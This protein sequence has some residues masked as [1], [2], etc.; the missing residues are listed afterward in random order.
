MAEGPS[1]RTLIHIPTPRQEVVSPRPESPV[2]EEPLKPVGSRGIREE[3]G[4]GLWRV[5][6]KERETQTGREGEARE[7]R[8][9]KGERG[10]PLKLRRSPSSYYRLVPLSL[11]PIPPSFSR[12]PVSTHRRSL[13]R[14]SPP[15]KIRVSPIQLPNKDIKTP[16][17]RMERQRESFGYLH[18]RRL[19]RNPGLRRSPLGRY[20]YTGES[21][22]SRMTVSKSRSPI[23]FPK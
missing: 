1:V 10:E 12:S 3:T 14:L 22:L 4:T 13:P 23:H 6:M 2:M 16:S 21:E 18:W 9:W 20:E 17:R 7:M 11:F 15:P 5:R 19:R 8:D